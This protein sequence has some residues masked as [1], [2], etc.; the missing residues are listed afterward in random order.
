M[1]RLLAAAAAALLATAAQADN[2]KICVEGAYPPFSM[3][4]NAGQL[5]GF[6][7]DITNALCAKMGATCEMVQT[8]WDAIIPTLEEGKCDAII[9][10][11]SITPERQQ[12][13][14]FSKKYQQTPARFAA[15]EGVDWADT[16]EGMTGKFVCVQRGTIHQDYIEKK[17]PSARIVLYP[18]QEEAYLDLTAGRCDA[19]MADSLAIEEGFLNTDAGKGYA[20]FGEPHQDPAIHGEGA[21]IAVRKA[22][23]ALAD[24]FSAAIA[25]IRADGTYKAINDKY[26]AFDIYGK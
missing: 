17:F 11:M 4:N 1:K 8:E 25:A 9:A 12:R 13:I 15:T 16:D 26:F 21:G 19:T 2:L 5:E 14:S 20:F 22:D 23:T 7:I 3:I 18:T 10:S 6:D 24:R